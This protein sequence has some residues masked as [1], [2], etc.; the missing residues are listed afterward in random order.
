MICRHWY[1]GE[2]SCH[3]KGNEMFVW[4]HLVLGQLGY[5]VCAVLDVVL[6]LLYQRGKNVG[7]KP[8]GVVGN[9]P[10]FL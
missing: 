6:G 9:G 5:K 10:S 8:G 4:E 3:V 7:H 2:E 1:A